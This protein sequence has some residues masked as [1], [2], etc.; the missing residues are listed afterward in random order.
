MSARTGRVQ[1]R[2]SSVTV[3][4]G[5]GQMTEENPCRPVTQWPGAGQM[6][7]ENP[8]RPVT[9]RPLVLAR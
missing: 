5:A 3:A 8:C 6:T 9:L 7:E 2:L 1:R 4:L